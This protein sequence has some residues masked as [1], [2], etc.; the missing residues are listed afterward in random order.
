MEQTLLR[1]EDLSK[2]YIVKKSAF[3]PKAV[4]KAV[5]NISFDIRDGETL[6]LIG[7]SGSGKSTTGELIL[8]LIESDSGRI[9]YRDENILNVSDGRMR[10]LRK[11]MQMIFQSTRE[12]LD[13][14][15][16]IGELVTEPLKIYNI[17]ENSDIESEVIKL[18]NMVGMAQ[19]EKDKFGYQLSGGQRQRVGIARAIACR[20]R[21]IVCDEPVSALD[22]S[23]QGQILNLLVDLKQEL[24]L[25]Y[26]FISHDLKVIRFISD[27]IAVMYKGRIIETG[28]K[29]EIINNPQHDYTKELIGSML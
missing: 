23:V 15:M 4:V 7:E 26:L 19:K 8:R 3:S 5:D 13:P 11:E 24:K 25:T 29:Y 2:H 18:L 12:A 6:G 28:N 16:T 20:P 1:V 17:V 22:V 9:L 10:S 21:F 27:R 14:K